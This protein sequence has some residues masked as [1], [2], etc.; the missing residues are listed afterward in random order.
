MIGTLSRGERTPSP[1]H[2]L[3]ERIVSE[4]QTVG[5]MGLQYPYSRGVAVRRVGRP[6]R[7]LQAL[8]SGRMRD[9]IRT[10]KATARGCR[11][12]VRWCD[13]EAS[14]C[15]CCLQDHS[16]PIATDLPTNLPTE[17]A[18]RGGGGV[19]DRRSL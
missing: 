9:R 11:S 12:P 10:A 15:E 2:Q 8:R 3:A 16:E 7:A 1:V 14:V 6:H 4:G 18:K 13:R 17:P 19:K 5:Y